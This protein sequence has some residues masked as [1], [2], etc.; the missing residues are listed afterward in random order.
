MN[1]K[2]HI[3]NWQIYKLSHLKKGVNGSEGIIYYEDII[4]LIEF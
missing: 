3:I 2:I 4:F 1:Y